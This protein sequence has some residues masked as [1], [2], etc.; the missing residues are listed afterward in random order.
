[1][2]SQSLLLDI[3]IFLV[4]YFQ[5]HNAINILKL[6]LFLPLVLAS[7]EATRSAINGPPTEFEVCFYCTTGDIMSAYVEMFQISLIVLTRPVCSTST[8]SLLA[9][10][11]TTL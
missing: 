10:F 4:L 5:F 1:M 7:L 2:T 11:P 6:A 8:S 3:A 9:S